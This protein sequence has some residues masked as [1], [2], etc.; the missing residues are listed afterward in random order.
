MTQCLTKVCI[1]PFGTHSAA[2]L[3]PLVHI[4][5]EGFPIDVAPT[6]LC[7]VKGAL[8]KDHLTLTDHHHRTATHFCA[9][10]DVVLHILER[11]EIGSNILNCKICIN[12]V[13]FK[14]VHFMRFLCH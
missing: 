11:G 3:Y 5:R 8:L 6:A 4:V 2:S 10:K 13:F 14:G 9:L 7:G 12:D 1:P